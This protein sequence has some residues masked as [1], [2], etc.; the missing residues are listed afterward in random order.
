MVPVNVDSEQV[1]VERKR[2]AVKREDLKNQAEFETIARELQVELARITAEK[3]AKIAAAEAV[4]RALANAR[5]QVW[6][7]PSSMSRMM[8]SF[9]RG[10]QNGLF[11]E[12]LSE[13]V[14][15]ELKHAAMSGMGAA[16]QKLVERLTGGKSE[17]P[18]A[19]PAAD[20]EAEGTS[21]KS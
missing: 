1:E 10:Q 18:E 15:E 21:G 13:G 4:G 20:A 17:Q 3:E 8:E 14:P 19:E 16:G 5:M 7:D 11:V 2:V 9:L 6:G 12:G